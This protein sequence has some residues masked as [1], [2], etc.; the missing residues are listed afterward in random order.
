MTRNPRFLSAW[1]RMTSTVLLALGLAA[2]CGD[3]GDEQGEEASEHSH[4]HH[5]T[6]HD[7]VL[8]ILKDGDG[9]AV[10]YV[11]MKLHDDKG[12]LELWLGTDEKMEK[13]FEL[14]LDL[15]ILAKMLDKDGKTVELRVRNQDENEDENGK[16]NIREGKTNYFIFPGDTGTDAAWLMGSDFRSMCVISFESGGKKYASQGFALVPHTHGGGHDHH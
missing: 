3:P 13:P 4:A 11:E 7:G 9:T 1:S 6:P 15:V 12:D 2:G 14:P 5:S 16:G 10:G 8:A